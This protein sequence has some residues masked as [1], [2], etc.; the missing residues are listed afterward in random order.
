MKI[1]TRLGLNTW[2]SLGVVV[3]MALSLTW[4]FRE[5]DKTDRNENLANEMRKEAFERIILRDEYLLYREKRA[6]IQWQAKSETLRGILETA[7]EHFTDDEEK[8]LLREVQRNFDATFFLFSTI[9]E[10]HAR[11][12]L[13]ARKKLSF[14]ERESRL[15]GQV[16]LKAYALQDSIEKL[17]ESTER[18]AKT[19]RNRGVVL[20][21]FSVLGGGM[22]IVFNSVL[23]GRTMTRRM[24]ALHEGVKIIG[25]GNFDHRI[26]TEG[27]DELAD[28]ASE[29]NQM[30]AILKESHTSVENLQQEINERKGAEEA[31]K[32]SEEKF[33]KAFQTSPYAITITR[34]EDGRF[35]N[36]NDAFTSLTGFTREE[37]VARSSVSLQLWVD[38]ED[39]KRVVSALLEGR[40]VVGQEFLFRRKNG[41]IITGL[42]SA[43]VIHLRKAPFILSSIN[44]ITERKQ[45]EEQ[46]HRQRKLLAAINSVFFETLTADSEESV[47]K[48]CLRVAQE[49]TDSK[50]GFIG[51]ITPKGLYTTTALSDPGWE[52]CRIPETQANVLIK[53]MVIR[54]IWG[55]VILK[56][57]SL[58]VNDPASYPDRVGIPE[59]HPP[60]TSFLG[61]P[62]KDQGKVIGMIAMGNCVAGYT[63]DHQQDMEALSVA[64]VEAIRRKKIEEEIKKLNV[65]LEQRVLDRTAQLEAAN[66]ELEA[67]SYSVS[68][69]LRAPLRSIDGFSQALFEE[70]GNKLDDTGKTYLER[71]RKATQRMGWLIDDMLKLSRVAKSE[72]HTESVDLSSMARAIAEEHQKNN[73]GRAVDVTVREG[74][75]VQGDPY[76]MR[77]AMQ[78]L[79]DNAWKFTG[80][81]AHPR[82]EFGTTVRDGKVVCFIRD[83]GTGFDMAYVGKLFS[84]F[85]RLHTTHEF[86]GTGIGL[87]TVQRIIHHHGGQVWA[88]GEVGKGAT[89]YFMLPS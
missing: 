21:I 74:I 64:F 8:T 12:E 57:Q 31:L 47:A 3:L 87:A 68:H 50:F 81:E 17:Y 89:F 9:L 38:E 88:A 63:A 42:F 55:Q 2:I 37:A 77:I 36:V 75:I 28:L 34:V 5:M 72:L 6:G 48:T 66:K 43:Q 62:L 85:Q 27:D 22:A 40:D 16:F 58:I 46:I 13:A 67:F 24:A 60:L 73:P 56:E 14:D 26:G 70:Y 15:I 51:E 84:A 86:P 61:V 52:A 11:E 79:M 20:V 19:A 45:A 78:N 29:S 82:I 41:E 53:D 54:G 4:S 33:S 7:K 71:V 76:L 49:I 32:E 10:R 69:D 18:T 1:R 44:D 23:T 30:A 39:R 83:N 80:K 35:I 25:G 65:E 59:G